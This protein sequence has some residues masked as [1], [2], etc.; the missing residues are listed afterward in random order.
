MSG[1][2]RFRS[3]FS[4]RLDQAVFAAYFL[5]GIVP[6]LALVWVVD[7]YVIPAQGDD[8]LAVWAWVAGIV[9]VGGLSL[10]VYF[11]LRQITARALHRMDADNRR[12]AALLQASRD[13]AEENH[14]E[15]I[16]GN[17]AGHAA[18]VS[19]A[20]A[21]LVLF[22]RE[23]DKP[24]EPSH[25]GQGGAHERFV[26]HGDAYTALAEAAL[27]DGAP[28]VEA[29]PSGTGHALAIPFSFGEARGAIVLAGTEQT[30]APDALDALTTLAGMA[31][32][33]LQRGDLED[34]QRNFFAHVTDLLVSAMDSH[35]VAR[36][37]HAMNVARSC[38]RLGRQLGLSADR[39]ERLHF[40]AMLH[41][42]GMLKIDPA[43]HTDAKSVRLHP[44]VGA[45]MLQRIRLWEPVAPLVLYHHEWWDGSG[46]PEGKSGEDIPL[47]SRIVAVADCIDAMWRP[48]G[49][50]PGANLGQI[51]EE[52]RRGSGTQFDPAVV[53]AFAALLDRRDFELPS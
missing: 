48:E 9:S 39:M 28:T 6:I 49:G 7:A 32:T 45:R 12:L 33:A 8:R 27:A 34:A 44:V 51:L 2:T 37:G 5:G 15:S 14:P 13:M 17:A 3:L 42:I 35:V 16:L 4:E 43:R 41:D 26:A 22:A 23:R 11:A 29:D 10:G 50:R 47:E 30:P 21:Q 25:T 46:Y 53:D 18:T 40:T 38:N 36:S 1:A 31:G 24:L 19:G 52:V 20:P